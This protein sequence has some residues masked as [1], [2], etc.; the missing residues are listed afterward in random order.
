VFIFNPSA[1]KIVAGGAAQ[2]AQNQKTLNYA[3]HK[4]RQAMLSSS[5]CWP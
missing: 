5:V 4:K 1:I 3:A 2:N